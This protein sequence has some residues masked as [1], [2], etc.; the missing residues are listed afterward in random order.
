[1]E[2]VYFFAGL[3]VVGLIVIVITLIQNKFFTKKDYNK[4]AHTS[5]VA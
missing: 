1:M 3:S 4:T 2:A 5:P